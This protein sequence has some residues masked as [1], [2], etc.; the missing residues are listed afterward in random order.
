MQRPLPLLVLPLLVW[1]GLSACSSGDG[2]AQSSGTQAHSADPSA[3]ANPPVA[4][5]AAVS[6]VPTASAVSPTPPTSSAAGPAA[7]PGGGIT[8][9]GKVSGRMTATACQGGIAQLEVDIDGQPTS[10][11]GIIDAKD[12]T[13]VAPHSAGYTLA[14]GAAA[15]KVSGSGRTFTV[16]G[17]RLIGI[18]SNDTVTATGTVTCP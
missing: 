4:T 11:A 14:K 15:P 13:F 6:S 9:T 17:T 3:S 16:H 18:L 10:Y 8:F 1:A 5:S 7:A 12:F 2:S